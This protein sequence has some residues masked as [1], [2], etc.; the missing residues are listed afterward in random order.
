MLPK[1][2]SWIKSITD[3]ILL[4]I[5][6]KLSCHLKLVNS[7]TIT[8]SQPWNLTT[9]LITWSYMKLTMCEFSWCDEVD[10]TGSKITKITDKNMDRFFLKKKRWYFFLFWYLGKYLYSTQVKHQ[11]RDQFHRYDH[12]ILARSRS[13][14]F[15]YLSFIPPWT[16]LY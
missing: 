6:K 3:I 8:A 4:N 10:L 16:S 1:F 7:D 2:L 11:T 5:K 14:L 9:Q 13:Y 12:N 15:F